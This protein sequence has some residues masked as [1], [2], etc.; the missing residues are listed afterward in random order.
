MAISCFKIMCSHSYQSSKKQY[1]TLKHN[2]QISIHSHITL[3][4]TD[5]QYFCHM[6]RSHSSTF[7]CL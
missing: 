6:S 7:S 2:E 4:N 5:I 3:C 1:I